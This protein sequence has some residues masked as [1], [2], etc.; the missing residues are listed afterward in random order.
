MSEPLLLSV[1]HA[2]L[3]IPSEVANLCLLTK[4]EIIED[5]DEGAAEIYLPLENEVSA[6][7]TTVVARAIVDM[8]R[9]EDDRGKD[10]VVKTHTC[11]DVQIYSEPPS[12]AISGIPRFFGET[13]TP[14]YN[15]ENNKRKHCYGNAHSKS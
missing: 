2:G 15:K 5:G 13:I 6:L 11:W 8:N 4:N 14:Q 9:A 7:V 1:P 12:E 3:T 10:G